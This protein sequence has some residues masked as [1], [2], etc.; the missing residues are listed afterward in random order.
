M[1]KQQQAASDFS[2]PRMTGLLAMIM[3]CKLMLNIYRI[4]MLNSVRM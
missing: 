2:L 1:L 4:E 3:G